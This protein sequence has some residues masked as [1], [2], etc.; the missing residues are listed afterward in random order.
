MFLNTSINT[1]W[2]IFNY[3]HFIYMFFIYHEPVINNEQMFVTNTTFCQKLNTLT[4]KPKEDK[5]KFLSFVLIHIYNIFIGKIC[6]VEKYL[7]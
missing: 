4:S 3:W 2:E 6:D 7:I 5:L 1:S